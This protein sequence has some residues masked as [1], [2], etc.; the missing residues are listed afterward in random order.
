MFYTEGS[1]SLKLLKEKSRINFWS[2]ESLWESV[3]NKTEEKNWQEAA[4]H[5]KDFVLHIK[6]DKKYG[7]ICDLK[8]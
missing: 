6:M 2:L 5:V 8:T 4:G 7:Y 3:W 1:C